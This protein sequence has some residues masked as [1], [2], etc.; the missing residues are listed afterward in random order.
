MRKYSSLDART[1]QILLEQ[2]F[3]WD[4][5]ITKVVSE[6]LN[7]LQ[8]AKAKQAFSS[9][10]Q[11]LGEEFPR[12]CLENDNPIN[13][14]FIN[15]APWTR[16]W[17]SWLSDALIEISTQTN[18]DNIIRKLTS[19]RKEDFLEVRSVLE[20]GLK[21][22]R[23]GFRL[24]LESTI[25]N[26]HGNS[27]KPDITITNHETNERSFIEI[28]RLTRSTNSLKNEQLFQ[29]IVFT[30]A[31][32]GQ[33]VEF[34]GRLFKDLSE[35]HYEEIS[36]ELEIKLKLSIGNNSFQSLSRDGVIDVGFAPAGNEIMKEWAVS[37]KYDLNTF[38]LPESDTLGR[39]R[40]KIGLKKYQLSSSYP[41]ILVIRNEDFLLNESNFNFIVEGL[42]ETIHKSQEVLAV[43]ILS[44]E[45]GNS[46]KQVITAGFNFYV[47]KTE[48]HAYS[49][50]TI[51]LFNRFC[52]TKISP[53][54][55][56]RIFDAFE[57]Y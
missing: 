29:T 35:Q 39:I 37:K 27:K 48:R 54:A 28:T 22:V 12:L 33:P 32:T 45:L 7:S 46:P 23:A 52:K 1:Q 4:A 8:I 9:L 13:D 51:L 34:S 38:A 21:L 17:F 2:Y 50:K 24:E 47:E 3:N 36:K 14:Y 26:D 18:I 6:E 10:R 31:S 53:H 25:V 56:M 42:L 40:G 30:Y 20:I 19:H 15:R 41:S 11:L 16:V 57:K 43:V 55:L 44:G 49:T 5:Q